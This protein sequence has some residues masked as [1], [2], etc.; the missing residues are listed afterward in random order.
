M[1]FKYILVISALIGAIYCDWQLIGSCKNKT[2]PFHDW[3]VAQN[4]ACSNLGEGRFFKYQCTSSSTALSWTCWDS[5]CTKCDQPYTAT[6]RTCSSS[7]DFYYDCSVDYP[8]FPALLKTSDY[9]TI[10]DTVDQCKTNHQ[11]TAS[12]LKTCLPNMYSY[13]SAMYACNGTD[14]S[15]L[16]FDDDNCQGDQHYRYVTK[17]GSSCSNPEYNNYLGLQSRAVWGTALIIKDHHLL[18][19]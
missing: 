2:H 1:Y 16:G 17:V 3:V 19:H 14:V 7:S 12:P 4:G 15:V 10:T 9:L 6:L 11:V 8:N 5:G 13:P 18:E